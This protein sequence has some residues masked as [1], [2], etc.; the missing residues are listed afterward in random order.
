M[1][2]FIAFCIG[3]RDL[4]L[5]VSMPELRSCSETRSGLADDAFAGRVAFSTFCIRRQGRH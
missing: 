4:N 3:F 2:S 1:K 5:F